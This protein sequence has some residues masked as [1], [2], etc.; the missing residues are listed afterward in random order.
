MN[1]VS[2]LGLEDIYKAQLK[3]K[4][5]KLNIKH[6]NKLADLDV[7]ELENIEVLFTYGNETPENIVKKMKSLK[8]IHSG[9][10]GIETMPQKALYEQNVFVTNSRGINS[11]TIA[12]Y[13]F[14]MLLNIV[15]NNYVFYEARKNNTWDL[16]NHLDELYEKSIGIFGLGNVGQ[17][18]AKRAKAFGMTVYGM[19]MIDINLDTVD[20]VYLPNQKDELISKCDYIVI[21]LPLTE[22]TKY[23]F[24]EKEFEIMKDTAIIMNVGR[25]P[26]INEQDL[27]RALKSKKIAGAVLDVFEQEPLPKDNLLWNMD[28]VMITPHI[29]GDRQM[30][31]MPRMMK[32]LCHNL[33]VYPYKE[34]MLNPVNLNLGF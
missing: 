32:I 13:V 17:E 31:Y 2:T 14:C 9:Q 29:A 19:N 22:Q 28:N 15:R 30:S 25:G 10:A 11:V 16:V 8:W 20:K 18:I 7:Q 4:F 12:E 1:I 23:M 21:C 5:P 6:I 34:K 3:E 24:S 33:E 27:I 26:I